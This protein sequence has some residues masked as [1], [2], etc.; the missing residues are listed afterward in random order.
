MGATFFPVLASG[1][2]LKVAP[3]R[4]A[5]FLGECALIRSNIELVAPSG[6]SAESHAAHVQQVS[7]RLRNIEDA[8]ALDMPF[9]DHRKSPADGP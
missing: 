7:E 8:A 5:D 6:E 2:W 3:D 4:V 1:D 9:R